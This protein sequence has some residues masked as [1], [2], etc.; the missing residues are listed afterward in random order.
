[1]RV[2]II[3][4]GEC[5][6]FEYEKY[7]LAM[8]GDFSGTPMLNINSMY[9]GSKYRLYIGT[10]DEII[11]IIR[12]IVDNGQKAHDINLLTIDIPNNKAYNNRGQTWTIRE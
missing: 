7:L 8:E 2:L 9:S 5:V 3:T 12:I 4:C 6:D 11:N 1:M 10:R